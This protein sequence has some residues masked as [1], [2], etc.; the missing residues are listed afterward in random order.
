MVGI[1]QGK[2]GGQYNRDAFFTKDG[3]LLDAVFLL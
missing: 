3:T 2:Q 1:R